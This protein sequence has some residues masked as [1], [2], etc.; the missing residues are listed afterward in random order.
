MSAI[1]SGDTTSIGSMT[2][3]EPAATRVRT[4]VQALESKSIPA[5]L[6][7]VAQAT[8]IVVDLTT[9]VDVQSVRSSSSSSVTIQ[10]AIIAKNKSYSNS[11]PK[12]RRKEP[13]PKS[14]KNS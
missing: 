10:R 11:K 5:M 13:T 7:T 14:K 4:L 8:A 1:D 12:L 6:V 3:K 9:D 2:V